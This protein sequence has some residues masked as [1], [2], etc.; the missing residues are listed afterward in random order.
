M[1]ALV[2]WSAVTGAWI[3]FLLMCLSN[4]EIVLMIIILMIFFCVTLSIFSIISLMI[5]PKSEKWELAKI[6]AWL[7]FSCFVLFGFVITIGLYPPLGSNFAKGMTKEKILSLKL[8]M[9]K[10]EVIAIMGKPVGNLTFKSLENKND[11][12]CKL[13][14]STPGI[15]D[16]WFEFSISL[17][18]DK[19]DYIHIERYDYGVYICHERGCTV[20]NPEALDELASY[21]TKYNILGWHVP[22]F[23]QNS[24]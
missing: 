22:K 8:G 6:T 21:S 1:R 14:Y 5:S 11:T 3:C 15:F 9:S 2:K 16:S 18:N 7:F 23:W 4:A 13:V 20:Y 10:N 12:V 24:Q 17:T 19:L